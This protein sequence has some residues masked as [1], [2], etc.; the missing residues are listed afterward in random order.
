MLVQASGELVTPVEMTKRAASADKLLAS[1]A[2][3]PLT[4][5][6]EVELQDA[7][8]HTRYRG[9][10]LEVTWHDEHFTIQ[11][12]GKRVVDRAVPKAWRGRK[13]R[14]A[15]EADVEC[16]NPDYLGAAVTMPT[17]RLA[18]ITVMYVGDETCWAPSHQL[19]VISW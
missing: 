16:N 8:S 7:E 15:S 4:E 10:G 9:A 14:L 1:H 2:W 5:V 19:H 18:V 17:T 12:G 11:D 13:Y 6:P 3:L